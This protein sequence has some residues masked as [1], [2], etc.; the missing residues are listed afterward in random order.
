ML[1]TGCWM[2]DD[3]FWMMDDG[4]W[5]R[6]KNDT[7]WWIKRLLVA[8]SYRFFKSKIRNRMLIS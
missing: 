5:I 6:T 7:G 4:Y 8:I 1:D 2:M 3:G